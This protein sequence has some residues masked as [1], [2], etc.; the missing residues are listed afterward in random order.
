MNRAW[1]R[2]ALATLAVL[3]GSHAVGAEKVDLLQ[4]ALQ[5]GSS[6]FTVRQL[7]T[8]HLQEAGTDAIPI[9][10]QAISTGDRE[11]R[12]RAMEV[13]LS[14]ALSPRYERRDR[15]LA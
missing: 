8:Q 11:V 1:M 3:V 13:L 9:L 2:L 12:S 7:A 4:C 5:L 15:A 6:D 14:H 10:V